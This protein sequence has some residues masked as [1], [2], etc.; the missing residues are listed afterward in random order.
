MIWVSH[1]LALPLDPKVDFSLAQHPLRPDVCHSDFCDASLCILASTS[2]T[3]V[4]LAYLGFGFSIHVDLFSCDRGV[5]TSTSL[6]L[7][8]LGG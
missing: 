8:S 7:N 1:L 2:S 4:E 6:S 3:M 5:D